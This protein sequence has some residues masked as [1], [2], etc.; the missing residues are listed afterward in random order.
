MKLFKFSV[1]YFL[2]FVPLFIC[3]QQHHFI[4]LQTEGKQPFYVRLDKKTLSSSVSGYL[5]IPRLTDGE[6]SFSVGFPKSDN[7]EQVFHCRIEGKDAGYIIKNFGEKGWGLFNL[8]TLNVV[9]A[10]TRVEKTETAATEKT[11][12]FATMLSGVVNDPSIKRNNSGEPGRKAPVESETSSDKKL[13]MQ[14]TEP[15]IKKQFSRKIKEGW[16]AAYTE[17]NK[18]GS[19]N[20]IEIMIPVE[21]KPVKIDSPEHMRSSN[22]QQEQSVQEP[23]NQQLT[24][25][26]TGSKDKSPATEP[27]GKT[28][29]QEKFLPVE[30]PVAVQPV[31]ESAE[32]KNDSVKMI[33]SDC[34]SLASE[35]DFLRL[36]KKM[37]AEDAEDGMINVAQKFFRSKCYSTEQIKNLSFL[38]LH[39]AGKYR[40][41][42]LAYRF[43]YD[44]SN[45][46]MLENQL[47][48][49]YY[50]SRFKAMVRH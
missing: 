34:K 4:Y 5:I 47:T 32:V 25:D 14:D 38:F 21:E 30:M 8:Q 45:Y 48:D 31:L 43:V 24:P 9:M 46:G 29:D 15:E 50:I 12:E 42:D 1:I 13:P 33:N 6:L 36:R 37:A 16:E 40:F 11:D 22:T 41:L 3:A 44:S 10:G 17:R 7:S 49:S 28:V 2:V 35:E 19:I 39:D 27:P 23:V 20:T 26:V 18:D